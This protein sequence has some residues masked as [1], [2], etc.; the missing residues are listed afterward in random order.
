LRQADI[1]VLELVKWGFDN[2]GWTKSTRDNYKLRVRAAEEWLKEN[3][4]RGQFAAKERDL[5]TYLFATTPNARNRNH[6]R[7][8]LQAYLR[9]PG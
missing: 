9:L 6:I 3:T 1:L 5:K 7:Q 2:R 4:G 8:A